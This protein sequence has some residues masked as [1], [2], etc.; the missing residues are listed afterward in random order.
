[1]EVLKMSENEIKSV[2]KKTIKEI[3]GNDL[4]YDIDNIGD[5]ESLLMIVVN[6]LNV[7]KLIMR[8]E[9]EFDLEFED[10]DIALKNWK[11]IKT[12]VDLIIRRK[13]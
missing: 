2:V 8:I 10:E 5:N 9:E 11:D 13:K 4:A 1:M 3:I 12:I 6:S 7:I